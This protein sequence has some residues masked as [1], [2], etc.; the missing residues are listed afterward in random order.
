MWSGSPSCFLFSVTLGIKLPYHGRTAGD[1]QRELIAQQPSAAAGLVGAATTATTTA[2]GGMPTAPP[3][4]A[5]YA[6]PDALFIGNGDLSIDGELRGGS[7]EVENCY[8][9]GLNP[10]GPE[11]LCLLA[12]RP[13]FDIDALELWAVMN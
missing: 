7:S 13:L 3:P 1:L 11:A 10:R 12:G 6:Q 4:L 9:C 8:G 5:F 2:A